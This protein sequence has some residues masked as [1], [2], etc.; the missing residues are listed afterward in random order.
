M[1]IARLVSLM[2]AAVLAVGL[3]AASAAFAAPNFTPVGGTFTGSAGLGVLEANNGAEK[4]DCTANTTSG[5]IS[6]AT[7]A[8][9]VVVKFTGC[10]SSS[11][12]KSNCSV[13]SKNSGTAGAVTTET[14]HGVLGTISSGSKAGLLLLPVSGKRFVTLLVNACTVETA[15]TGN[16]TGEISPVGTSQKTGKLVFTGSKGAQGI[17]EIELSTGGKAK[18]ELNAFGTAASENTSEALAFSANLEVT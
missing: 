5:T 18:S 10:T 16:I 9:G 17:T 4:V 13:S 8:G 1:K 12:T 2:F 11:G 3:L 6:S 7:L 14:L 15:V